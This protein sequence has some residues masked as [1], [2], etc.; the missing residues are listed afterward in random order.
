MNDEIIYFELNNWF[1]GINYPN[2][3]PF[4]KWLGDDNKLYFCCDRWCKENKLCVSIAI[5]DMSVNFC[6]TALRSWIEENCPKLLSDEED[7]DGNPY[8]EFLRPT[9]ESDFGVPFLEYSD[10]NIGVTWFDCSKSG[11]EALPKDDENVLQA[12][13]EWEKELY[14]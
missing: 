9:K 2:A 1:P 11:W 12:N 6:I 8:S 5:I 10:S 14:G 3:E 13:A 4:T 7:D